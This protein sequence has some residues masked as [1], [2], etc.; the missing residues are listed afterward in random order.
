MTTN[1]AAR[2]RATARDLYY[3]T[4]PRLWPLYPFLPLTRSVGDNVRQ[5]GLLY[6]AR[7]VS[8]QYGYSCTVF[9]T[10]LFSVPRTEAELLDRPR[11]VYDSF[12]ELADD[13]WT[14]D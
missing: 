12:D 8:G 1:H 6:D 13:G 14:V 7:G 10:I 11:V 4:H 9:L 5:C 2:R 3:F